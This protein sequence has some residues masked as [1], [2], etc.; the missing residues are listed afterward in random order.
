MSGNLISLRLKNVQTQRGGDKNRHLGPL[1]LKSVDSSLGHKGPE[2]WRKPDI[3]ASAVFFTLAEGTEI[4]HD[5]N[6]AVVPGAG[7]PAEAYSTSGKAIA[8]MAII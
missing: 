4:S 7:H 6:P 5:P 8:E 2:S 3:A 1:L